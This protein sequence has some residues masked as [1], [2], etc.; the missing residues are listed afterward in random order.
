MNDKQQVFTYLKGIPGRCSSNIMF[1]KSYPMRYGKFP[2][3]HP[4][5]DDQSPTV[6]GKCK[7]REPGKEEWVEVPGE[8]PTSD[9]KLGKFRSRGYWA[10]CFP[11]GDGITF[12]A[13]NG[14]DDETIL[15]DIAEC[16]QV[17]AKARSK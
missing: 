7:T 11:E 6:M 5:A 17:T 13:L 3:Q 12:E 9:T 16:F 1:P 14:Q 8:Q 10:S 15:K 4:C 2:A